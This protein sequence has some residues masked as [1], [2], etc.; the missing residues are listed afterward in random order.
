MMD[1]AAD[2]T[3]IAWPEWMLR[4]VGTDDPGSF[5]DLIWSVGGSPPYGGVSYDEAAAVYALLEEYRGPGTASEASYDDV[6]AF[7]EPRSRPAL[8]LE[9]F[10]CVDWI[11][12][13]DEGYS[14]QPVHRG[15]DLARQLRHDGAQ[16]SFLSFE[17]GWHVREG[18]DES[19]RRLT[20]AAL[21]MFLP[22]A[23][24]DEAYAKRVS[25]LAVNAVSLTA[26]CGDLV[27]ARQLLHDLAEVME[28]EY[29]EQL[30]LALGGQS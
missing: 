29:A 4:Y 19:S 20:R 23:E 12:S 6:H 8:A 7:L 5:D 2:P 11:Q 10:R 17:A 26:R 22:L 28:P 15:L 30:R 25:Q 24:A 21:D 9:T 1:S 18:D 3:T 16:A 27:G 14:L 13:D